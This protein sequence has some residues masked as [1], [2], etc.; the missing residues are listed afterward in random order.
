MDSIRSHT[1]ARHGLMAAL[2]ATGMYVAPSL[3]AADSAMFG[4]NLFQHLSVLFTIV[5]AFAALR[6]SDR[7]LRGKLALGVTLGFAL[8][9]AF[10]LGFSMESLVLLGLAMSVSVLEW[11]QH[12]AEARTY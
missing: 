4:M 7:E 12:T 5:L 11:P 3:F 2:I 6:I 1:L 8:L 10:M 9:A